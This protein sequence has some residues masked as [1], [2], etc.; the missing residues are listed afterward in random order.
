M[1]CDLVFGPATMYIALRRAPN[2]RLKYLRSW[3]KSCNWRDK[4]ETH[5]APPLLILAKS[6]PLTVLIFL[7][8]HTGNFPIFS[9]P[10]PQTAEKISGGIDDASEAC[11]SSLAQTHQ[12]AGS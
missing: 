10:S 11:V 7:P 5:A 2:P 9:V 3:C 4:L 8:Q 1:A 12:V 6:F